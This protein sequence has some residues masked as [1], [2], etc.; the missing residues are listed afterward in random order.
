MFIP[1]KIIEEI[2]EQ[3]DIVEVSKE[4][5]TLEQK[6]GKYFATCPF[7]KDPVPSLC[8]NPT[9]QFFYCFGCGANGSVINFIEK[10]EKLNFYQAVE[11]LI[12]K[13]N[14]PVALQF[15]N[16]DKYYATI[17]WI[18]SWYQKPPT[19]I[20]RKFLKDRN[21]TKESCEKFGIGHV[22]A[23]SAM[24]LPTINQ[25]RQNFLD[26]GI[27]QRTDDGG[28]KAFFR[29]RLMF[30]ICSEQGEP[31]GFIGRALYDKKKVQK[32]LISPDNILFQKSK[33]LYG[34]NFAKEYLK[35]SKTAVIVEGVIDFIALNQIRIHSTVSSLGTTISAF[36]ARLLKKYVD[37]VIIMY[38]GDIAGVTSTFKV[39]P[40]LLESG[41]EV[42]VCVLPQKEDPDSY[43]KKNGKEAFFKLLKQRLPL[44]EFWKKY[45]DIECKTV[46]EKK[47]FIE[48]LSYNLMKIKDDIT[49]ELLIK[50][51][52]IITGVE[53]RLVKRETR[54]Y[55][56]HSNTDEEEILKIFIKN[57]DKRQYI[58]NNLNP[59]YLI[60]Q[61]VIEVFK[62]MKSIKSNHSV[63]KILEHIEDET[64]RK[65]FTKLCSTDVDVSKQITTQLWEE[66]IEKQ[67][68]N[69][70]FELHKRKVNMRI[71]QV[72][73]KIK[74]T[75]KGKTEL[76]KLLEQKKFMDEE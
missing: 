60:N 5:L 75:G 45:Y 43:I 22:L 74:N 39:I 15:E 47:K 41:L 1:Y 72:I 35:S 48:Q 63:P 34:L 2:R 59:D 3:L 54:R 29:D 55:I 33:V 28:F 6:G 73:E 67:I 4:Y 42:E 13:Y 17:D 11:F 16:Y 27:L 8:I 62:V 14:I 44:M 9:E 21:I 36:Q 58:I 71:E 26:L 76:D 23:K 25:H 49:R 18:T 31:V 37:K 40:I 7:H 38:D 65:F 70:F 52:E 56:A 12:K 30:P 68:D 50:D 66:P 61:K 10:I 19:D 53:L 51:I 24:V 69:I 46:N 32:Y 57:T 20:V 64:I